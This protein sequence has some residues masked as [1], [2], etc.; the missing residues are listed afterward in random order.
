MSLAIITK[1][2]KKGFSWG[3]YSKYVHIKATQDHT[4]LVCFQPTV[5]NYVIQI[6]DIGVGETKTINK[7]DNLRIYFFTKLFYSG[8]QISQYDIKRLNSSQ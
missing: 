5:P 4:K 2:A 7:S 8:T 3:L 6:L 1:L